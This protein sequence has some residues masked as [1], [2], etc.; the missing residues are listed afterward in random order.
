V[1]TRPR[2]RPPASSREEIQAQA[3]DLFLEHGYDRTTIA[4]ITS[5]CGVGRTTLFRY[6]PSKA[7]IIWSSFTE[8]TDRLRR[9][10][11]GPT[12]GAPIMTFVRGAVVETVRGS[13]D[14]R[15]IWMRRFEVLD[16]SVDLRA[17]E[18]VQWL[19]WANAVAEA[20]AREKGLAPSEV[21][22]QAVG[23]ALQGAFLAVLR[24]WIPIPDPDERLLPL[25]DAAL[26][27]LCDVLQAWLDGMG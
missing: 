5:A 23:G 19:S 21:V 16:S 8:H 27:P 25:L 4:M 2:G 1:S 12:G 22:P 26:T 17:E 11:A 13:V 10:L 24:S 9:L 6:F 20:V 14:P 3:I 15:G 18:S 7:E